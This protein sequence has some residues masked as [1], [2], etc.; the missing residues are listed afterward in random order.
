MVQWNFL[1]Q[2]REELWLIILQII[3]GTK[4]L[5]WWKEVVG[6][7]RYKWA[8][9]GIDYNRNL[10]GRLNLRYTINLGIVKNWEFGKF[11]GEDAIHPLPT[12]PPTYPPTPVIPHAQALHL[13]GW[14]AGAHHIPHH[15]HMICQLLHHD[16]DSVIGTPWLGWGW[17]MGRKMYIVRR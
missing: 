2:T 12:L 11:W 10:V 4:N 6:L 8:L 13:Q 16:I 9:V 3:L 14:G 5:L 17:I 15:T 1:H 7:L